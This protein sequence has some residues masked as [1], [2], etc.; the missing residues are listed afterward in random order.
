M[1]VEIIGEFGT[2]GAELEWLEAEG[3][4]AI[5]H[6]KKICG[7]PPPEME[8]EIVWQE[9]ELGNYPVIGL[10]WEDA[11]R[12]TPWNYI[13][14]CEV[15]L[16]AYENNGELPPGWSMPPVQSDDEDEFDDEPLNP[17]E[18]PE[19]PETLDFFEVQRYVSTLTEWALES[20]KRERGK[21]RL[22][23]SDDDGTDAGEKVE[24]AIQGPPNP[25]PYQRFLL[26]YLRI[27]TRYARDKIRR[28]IK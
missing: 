6:L 1:P 25:T 2:P 10:V 14:R 11:M 8:L 12:G 5:Q 28:S 21:P 22:V 18:P 19:P 26:T 23:E 20:S 27:L 3:K 15:A 17:D 7:D 24:K 13:S 4:L 9:H 16:T